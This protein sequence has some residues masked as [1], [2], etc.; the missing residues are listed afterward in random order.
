M[1]KVPQ[2]ILW[3][4]SKID[5]SDMI[6]AAPINKPVW[7]HGLNVRQHTPFQ[8]RR[9]NLLARIP[10]L[11]RGLFGAWV[12]NMPTVYQGG[13]MRSKFEWRTAHVSQVPS[14][15]DYYFIDGNGGVSGSLAVSNTATARYT[16]FTNVGRDFN[17]RVEVPLS[18]NP[19][20]ATHIRAELGHLS[21]EYVCLIQGEVQAPSD[22]EVEIE[23]L[24]P[25]T[26]RELLLE[27]A[28][29]ILYRELESLPFNNNRP[30]VMSALR[31]IDSFLGRR[32]VG[33]SFRT[34]SRLIVTPDAPS[35][36][37]LMLQ[38]DGPARLLFAVRVRDRESGTT[39][40]SEFM[41]VIV[42][43]PR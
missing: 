36:F 39:S 35:P 27:T 13:E 32:Y 8:I 20:V 2:P 10:R 11:G 21:S 12:G 34:E 4:S 3:W 18:L 7:L 42:R 26:S 23:I 16:S 43:Q 22:P 37:S 24:D 40:I 9:R 31:H 33:F 17:P 1:P 5:G 15:E 38:G 25:G 30:F 29:E 19:L 41:P 28:L 14:W 6:N